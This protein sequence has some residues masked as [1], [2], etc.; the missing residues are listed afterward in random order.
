MIRK[1][2]VRGWAI[3]KKGVKI[4]WVPRVVQVAEVHPKVLVQGRD[5]TETSNKDDNR[6]NSNLNIKSLVNHYNRSFLTFQYTLPAIISIYD[7]PTQLLSFFY[8]Q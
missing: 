1:Q 3:E 4:D 6:H 7:K 2:K 8:H 5:Q